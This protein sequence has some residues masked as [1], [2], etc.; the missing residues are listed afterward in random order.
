M[1]DIIIVMQ[2]RKIAAQKRRRSQQYEDEL[3]DLAL[4]TPTEAV[5]IDPAVLAAVRP[6][7]DYPDCPVPPPPSVPP[8]PQ[9]VI[10]DGN[11]NDLKIRNYPL[12]KDDN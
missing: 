9:K 8:P 4:A 11:I 1:S 6:P 2:E 10:F 3:R 7:A 5:I 12:K